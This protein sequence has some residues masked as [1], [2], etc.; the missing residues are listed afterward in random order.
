MAANPK[1]LAQELSKRGPHSVLRGDLALAGLPGVVYT[2]AEGFN[3]PAVAF[4]HG[5]LTGIGKYSG[6]LEHLAS[7]GIVAGA[8]GTERGPVPS[9]LGLANDLDTT[10]EICTGVRLGTGRISVHPDRLG[11]VGHGMGAGAAVLAAGRRD[12]AAVAALYPAPTS[13]SAASVAPGV[14]APGL[15]LVG[16][17]SLGSMNSDAVAV[18]EAW[19]GDVQLRVVDKANDDG[20]VEGR[21]LLGA[22]GIG[23][24][25]RRTQQRTRAL[26]TGF[27]LH[28]LTGDKTYAMFS[29]PE[30]EF[31][32]VTAITDFDTVDRELGSQINQL[33]S[34]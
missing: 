22:L 20:L 9:P 12:V 4:A 10:L 23:G 6:L 15:V 25:E 2:P 27:L 21:R 8:P 7:W 5:W 32:G 16:E 11:F 18:A 17:K 3:L 24:S 14:D 1:S 13:P 30:T 34:P 29:D 33:L 28:T 26:L 31:P 19:G